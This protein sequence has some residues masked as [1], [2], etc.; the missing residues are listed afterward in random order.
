M[1]DLLLKYLSP[2]NSDGVE[3]A[4]NTTLINDAL[5][6]M[7]KVKPNTTYRLRIINISNMASMQFKIQSH[8]MTVIAVDGVNVEK[9]VVPQDQSLY[10]A[11]AQRVDILFTTKPTANQNYFFVSSLDMDMYGDPSTVTRNTSFGY[12]QYNP[13]LPLPQTFIPKFKPIDDTALVPYDKQPI[14]GPVTR[15]IK[16]QVQFIDDHYDIN[17][18]IPQS[19]ILISLTHCD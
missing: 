19:F 10:I 14:L 17:R 9:F 11:T 13:A 6:T 3:P 12:L 1:P 18:Y 5:S 7:L 4:P 2:E 16:L 8:A 15:N